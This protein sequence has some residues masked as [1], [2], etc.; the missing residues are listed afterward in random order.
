MAIKLRTVIKHP[1]A[2][3]GGTGINVSKE[4]GTYTYALDFASLDEADTI[5]DASAAFVPF[6]TSGTDPVVYE[7]ISLEAF[8][9][10]AA[11]GLGI[12]AFMIY[13]RL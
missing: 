3:I 2:V 12:S 7:R 10:L 5:P 8:A 6:Y 9:E 11:D 1:A 13:V 4:N